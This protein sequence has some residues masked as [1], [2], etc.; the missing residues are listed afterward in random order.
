M[1]KKGTRL[2]RRN[3][4]NLN[5]KQSYKDHDKKGNKASAKEQ[6]KSKMQNKNMGIVEQK[7]DKASVKEQIESKHTENYIILETTHELYKS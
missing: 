5:V 2:A 4:S 1:A 6:I 3:K 7:R